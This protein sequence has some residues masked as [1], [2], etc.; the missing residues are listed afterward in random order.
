MKSKT[1]WGIVYY[2]FIII[3]IIII[4]IIVIIIIII[5]ILFK[6]NL[7][8]NTLLKLFRCGCRA[9]STRVFEFPSANVESSRHCKQSQSTFQKC[10]LYGDIFNGIAGIPVDAVS[11]TSSD[12]YW[13]ST[14]G[15][16]EI[17][18][19]V[20]IS[21]RGKKKRDIDAML[22]FRRIIMSRFSLNFEVHFNKYSRKER[23]WK[24][25]H[26]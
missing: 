17:F 15:W 1:I 9:F 13:W 21:V 25:S 11:V 12:I 7:G 5:I 4:F 16:G 14:N 3:I 10:S 2:K 20:R 24:K 23:R 22:I 8:W 19:E 18:V 6:T 26:L